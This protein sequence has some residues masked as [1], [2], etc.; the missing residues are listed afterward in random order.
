MRRLSTRPTGKVLR[1]SGGPTKALGRVDGLVVARHVVDR[2][3]DH[4]M[5]L[6]K[7]VFGS[8]I[9]SQRA[10]ANAAQLAQQVTQ[11]FSVALGGRKS[12]TGPMRLGGSCR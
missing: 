6:G 7:R 2:S 3:F 11:V 1:R 10:D 9:Q 12:S 8:S 4:V 5:V